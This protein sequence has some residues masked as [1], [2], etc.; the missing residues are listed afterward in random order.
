MGIVQ[1]EKARQKIL[2][3]ALKLSCDDSSST[4][5]DYSPPSKKRNINENDATIEIHDSFWSCFEEIATT[6][7]MQNEFMER[8]DIAN[9]M[10][11]YLKTD[12]LDRKGRPLQVV[13]KKRRAVSHFDKVC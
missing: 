5:S 4:D 7:S 3:E 10:D 11:A 12:R 2:L 1:T 9:G 13:V 6:S 8:N